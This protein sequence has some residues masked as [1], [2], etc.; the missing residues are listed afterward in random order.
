M[1][2]PVLRGREGG[3]EAVKEMEKVQPG[4]VEGA[5]SSWVK[6]VLL[7]NQGKDSPGRGNSIT[8]AQ[9]PQ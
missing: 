5:G 3:V 2:H 8:K 9:R 1:G 6:K 7:A 4:R